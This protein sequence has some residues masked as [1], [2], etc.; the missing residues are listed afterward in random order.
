MMDQICGS[1]GS[2]N[3]IFLTEIFWQN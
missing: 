3:D 1:D 2:A